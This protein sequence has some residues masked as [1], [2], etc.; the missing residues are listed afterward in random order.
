VWETNLG[1]TFMG[2]EISGNEEDRW[3]ELL[4]RFDSIKWN[5]K[6]KFILDIKLK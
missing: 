2:R 4:E 5:E 3:K 6:N 1:E